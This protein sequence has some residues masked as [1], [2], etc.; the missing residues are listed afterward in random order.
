MTT[1][2]SEVHTHR[3]V[4]WWLVAVIGLAAAVVALG[5]WVL[6]DQWTRVSMETQDAMGMIDGANTAFSTGDAAAIPT[7]Y[8]SSAVIRSA[9]PNDTYTGLKQISA[10]ADGHFTAKRISPVT[11]IGPPEYATTFV[12]VTGA[13]GSKVTMISIFQIKPFQGGK[14]LKIVRQWNLLP[15]VTPPLDNAEVT[16]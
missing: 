13:D 10:L 7:Y 12:E 16:R 8:A 11:V 2:S 9:L 4:N 15:Q 5:A 14:F 6:V 1:Y 3:H